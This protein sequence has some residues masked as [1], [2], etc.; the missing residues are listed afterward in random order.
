[1]AQATL[2]LKGGSITEA[3]ARPRTVW[4]EAW[5][6]FRRIRTAVLGAVVLLTLC[7]VVLIGPLIYT[8]SPTKTNFAVAQRPPSAEYP[9]GTDDL[10][11]DML[12]RMLFGGR[13]SLAVGI[14]AMLISILLGTVIG[15]LAGFFGGWVD[16]V[17]MRI[18]DMFLALPA[19]AVVLLIGA[20]Y[21]DALK[22]AFGKYLGVFVLVVVVIG[23]L[24]W[25]A[26]SRLVRGSF[27]S[28]KEREFVEAARALG[29]GDFAIMF[30][31]ILPNSM[32]PIVVSATL[33][34][35]S[36]II[37]ESVLSFL[38]QGFPSD[39]PTWGRLLF[40]NKEFIQ[41]APYLVIW[42]GLAI[43]LTVLC[44]NY[45]GDGLREALDPRRR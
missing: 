22:A 42:P 5:R 39:V 9:L 26:T 45:L 1:M 43:F 14:T 37:T 6:R 19:L 16:T 27:L 33:G 17:L 2:P 32:A 29:Q 21:Q 7:V 13:I 40:E 36:A 34:V 25:M 31:H 11:R 12:A 41:L 35:G 3:A 18:T 23:L 8:A 24:Q 15:A 20:L 44:V 38:G 4:S 28:L 10:G 30:R